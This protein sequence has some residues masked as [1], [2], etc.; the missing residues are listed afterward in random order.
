MRYV[1][2]PL[3]AGDVV[4][5]ESQG[6]GGYV[7]YLL[8]QSLIATGRERFHAIGA[9]V[10]AGVN[11]GLNLLLI[12]TWGPAGAAW[13]T[14][15]TEGTLLGICLSGLG[16]LARI[17]PLG[18]TLL[19]GAAAGLTVAGGWWGLP[20]RP[21]SQGVLA[22]VVSAVVWEAASPGPLRTLL[23]GARARKP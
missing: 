22:L 18:P 3:R 9:A 8:T 13:A 6:G 15:A 17:I 2:V 14:V 19:T 5:F 21:L 20:D 16:Q 10:C 23:S 11:L 7:N 12:P 1:D 4:R